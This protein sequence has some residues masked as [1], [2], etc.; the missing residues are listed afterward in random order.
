VCWWQFTYWILMSR[1]MGKAK[2]EQVRSI[3]RAH[4]KPGDSRE[5]EVMDARLRQV[6]PILTCHMRRHI[7]SA[8]VP[9][10][11]CASW[12]PSVD[13]QCKADLASV[14]GRAALD[15]V[16]LQAAARE[17]VAVHGSVVAQ[18]EWQFAQYRENPRT[19]WQVGKGGG[20]GA[21][22]SCFRIGLHLAP[23]R[24]EGACGA[25]VPR[26]QLLF[27]ILAEMAPGK[28]RGVREVYLSVEAMTCNG[29]RS[30]RLAQVRGPR[31]TAV[32]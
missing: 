29:D 20:G 19:W 6:S 2:E 17:R 31:I 8:H 9:L 1:G 18:M 11:A 30:L 3:F 7:R 26:P 13:W 28:E 27:G 24:S 14:V 22:L 12:V 15:E 5:R 10:G 32:L 25:C 23:A 16:V 4:M 21:L